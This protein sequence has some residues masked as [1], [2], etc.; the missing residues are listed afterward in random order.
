MFNEKKLWMERAGRR[1]RDLGRYLRY[2]FNGHLVVVLL[3]LIGSAGYF[4]QNWIKGL[5]AGFPVE[6]IMAA[7]IGLFLT[8]SPVYNFLLEADQVFLL[9]LETKMKQYFYRSGLVSLGFQGYILLLVFALL[10]PMYAHVN[11]NGFRMFLPFLIVLIVIKAWNLAV[12]WRIHYDLDSAAQYWDR[13]LRFLIN[14]IFSYLLFK[15]ANLLFLITLAVI[16]FFYDRFLKVRMLKK[17]VKWDALIRQEEKRMN[18]FYRL[19]NLFTDVPILKDTVKRRKWLDF[20]LKWIPFT[21]QQTYL[22]LFTRTFLRS[23]DY[24]GLFLRLTVIGSIALYFL[25]FGLVQILFALLFIYIT[26]FQLLPLWM[27]HQNKLWVDL[28]P[29]Q[30]HSKTKAFTFLLFFILA[31]QAVLFAVFIRLK[32]D[33]LAAGIEL[34]V[35]IGFC[36][37]FV[38]VYSKGRLIKQG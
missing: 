6:W 38:F 10:M 35:G 15:Q 3:F 19:A 21:Q 27:H 29:V 31:S 23:G 14:G 2:I 7:I 4:Y 32:G 36:W 1:T 22:F 37:F 9:P 24:L 20:L 30:A 8:Y 28:Y 12:S 18:S 5:E 13:A 34:L 17:G 16:M 11:N 26:G 33:W 25:S